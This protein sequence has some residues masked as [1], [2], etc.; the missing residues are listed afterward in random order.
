MI[1]KRELKLRAWDKIDNKWRYFV[2]GQ[3]MTNLQRES[4]EEKGESDMDSTHWCE[5][6]RQ[7]PRK[8]RATKMRS[9]KYKPTETAN[10][11][12]KAILGYL[13]LNRVYCSRIQSQG[14]FNPK[15]KRWTKGTT[16]KG[17]G[18]IIAIVNG[19]AWMIEVKAGKDKQSPE[20]IQTQKD[21]NA[22][23]GWY[24]IVRSFNEFVTV[25]LMIKSK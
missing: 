4:W 12:T 24:S 13:A 21:V 15:L 17:I 7:H 6:Y 25:F 19:Y 23:G 10:G 16:R 14:Q 2:I 1:M 8:P 9:G 20:Q 5:S 22:S 3:S 11:I 18:D